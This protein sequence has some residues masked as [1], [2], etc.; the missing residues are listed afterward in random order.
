MLN[1]YFIMAYNE[2]EFHNTCPKTKYQS[3]NGILIIL[4]E[5]HTY[6]DL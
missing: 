5:N 1:L 4:K 2:I 6:E 3:I